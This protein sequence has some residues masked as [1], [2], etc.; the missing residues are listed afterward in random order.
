MSVCL[1]KYNTYFVFVYAIFDPIQ[2]FYM[3]VD[4]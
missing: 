1:I 3:S 4:F 2:I